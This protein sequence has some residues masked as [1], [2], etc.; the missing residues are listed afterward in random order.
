MTSLVIDMTFPTLALALPLPN[1][2]FQKLG[3]SLGVSAWIAQP[4]GNPEW[5]VHLE[6]SATWIITGERQEPFAALIN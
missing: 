2:T 5:K 6:T 4:A 1:W 3:Y